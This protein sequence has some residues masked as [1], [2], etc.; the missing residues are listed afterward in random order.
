M[1]D[2]AK[3]ICRP[4]GKFYQIRTCTLK[5]VASAAGIFDT[6]LTVVGHWKA[7]R[8]L[9]GAVAG[10][11][12]CQSHTSPPVQQQETLTQALREC[13]VAVS[14]PAGTL[15]AAYMLLR[16]FSVRVS[17]ERVRL[18]KPLHTQDPEALS[19]RDDG[20]PSSPLTWPSSNLYVMSSLCLV[21]KEILGKA[22]YRYER[23][24]PIILGPCQEGRRS[25][26]VR[27]DV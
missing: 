1:P 16:V 21:Q 6:T 7:I 19:A 2:I 26:G 9:A 11:G 27:W 3:A 15:T 24:I 25:I 12:G 23:S 22:I 10:Q 17:P 4:G 14:R 13:L 5:P 8:R 20:D 18:L